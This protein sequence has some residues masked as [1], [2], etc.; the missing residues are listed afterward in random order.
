[1]TLQQNML[2]N[3]RIIE[4]SSIFLSA[5]HYITKWHARS[6]D[7]LSPRFPASELPIF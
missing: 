2:H 5:L 4:I 6:R 3:V 1:M 7:L